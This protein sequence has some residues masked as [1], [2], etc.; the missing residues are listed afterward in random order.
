M[1]YIIAVT[2]EV[3]AVEYKIFQKTLLK[4]L[5]AHHSPNKNGIKK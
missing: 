2:V 5:L 3:F 4:A 1:F